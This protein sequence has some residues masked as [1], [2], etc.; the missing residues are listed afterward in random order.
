MKKSSIQLIGVLIAMWSTMVLAQPATQP[1]SQPGARRGG[2]APAFSSPRDA[3]PFTNESLANL[4]PSLP[5]LIITGDSTAAR[6]NPALRGW[7]AVLVDYFDTSR[8]NLVNRAIG[9]QRF[10]TYIEQ[11]W[12]AV[13]E[14]I[15]KGDY[16]VIEFGHNNGP[17]AG[18]GEETEQSTGR[19]G[20]PVTMHTHGWYLRKFIADVRAKGGIP[21]VSTITPRDIWY[22][23]KVERVKSLAPRPTPEQLMSE[24]KPP[25]GGGMSDWSRQVAKQENVALVDH[26]TIIADGYDALGHDAVN[27]FFNDPGLLH[28]NTDGAIFNCEAFIAGLKAI[29]DF[30]LVNYLNDKGKAVPAYKPKA[31]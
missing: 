22:K 24:E 27:K 10:N 7:A 25:A 13:V 31:Q 3:L 9:G 12:P 5:T 11:Y 20:Q 16:V 2:A 19:G 29:P 18:I 4:N 26:T 1:A 21:I 6:G 15:K 8:I 14:A 23:D 17:L 30:P 28:T